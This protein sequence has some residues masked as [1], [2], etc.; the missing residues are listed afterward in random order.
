MHTLLRLRTD[1]SCLLQF[2]SPEPVDKSETQMHNQDLLKP[3]R[4]ADAQPGLVVQAV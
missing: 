2:T 1:E 4:E 3:V